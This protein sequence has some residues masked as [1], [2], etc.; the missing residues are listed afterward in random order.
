MHYTVSKTEP[1]GGAFKNRKFLGIQNFPCLLDSR[2]GFLSL[3]V[4][5]LSLCDGILNG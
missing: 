5:V 4:L 1:C 2:H 3:F